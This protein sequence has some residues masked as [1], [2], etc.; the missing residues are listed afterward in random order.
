MSWPRV[1]LR[2]MPHPDIY[3]GVGKVTRVESH[4][5]PFEAIFRGFKS[6]FV[7]QKR[8]QH[9]GKLVD[10]LTKFFK[11]CISVYLSHQRTG[12]WRKK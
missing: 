12:D 6:P 5:P 11:R 4:Q 1:A 8:V 7:H 3:P 10:N 9:I 2:T